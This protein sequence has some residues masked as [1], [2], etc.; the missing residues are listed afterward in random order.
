MLVLSSLVAATAWSNLGREILA[1]SV[2]M[3]G[4]MLFIPAWTLVDLKHLAPKPRHKAEQVLCAWAH[5]A[6]WQSGHIPPFTAQPLCNLLQ[7][8]EEGNRNDGPDQQPKYCSG[9][10]VAFAH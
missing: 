4:A 2:V 8:A 5:L 3:F 9:N 1:H 10:L 6:G 7:I